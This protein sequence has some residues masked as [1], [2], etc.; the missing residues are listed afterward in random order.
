QVNALC[1]IMLGAA[2]LPLLIYGASLKW[3]Q[4]KKVQAGAVLLVAILGSGCGSKSFPSHELKSQFFSDVEELG[5]RGTGA[6]Q[7]NKPRSVIVDKEQNIFVMDITGRMQKFTKN[8]QYAMAWQMPETDIGKPKGMT[9]DEE[10]NVVLVEPHYSRVNHFTSNGQLLYQWGKAGRS[11][12]EFVFPRSIAITTN[13]DSYLSEY[14]LAE[15]IQRFS[16]HGEKFLASIGE[17]G[18]GPGQFNRV[19]GLGLDA[20]NRLYAADSCNHRIQVFSP[21]GKLLSIFGKAGS[22]LGEMSYPY[23][24]RIDKHGYKFVCEFGNSRIQVFGPANEPLEIIGNIGSEPGQFFN[25]WSIAL[26]DQGNLYVADS[27]NHRVQIF[28]RKQ[29]ETKPPSVPAT[30]R[31]QDNP[32]THQGTKPSRS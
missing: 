29:F 26:D 10:G 18:N 22:G 25:P 5:V 15:R 21:D 23:D 20:Q 6:G 11:P 32:A 9:I 14:G 19:E 16:K 17:P 1:V 30:A 13:G 4:W 2:L 8:R 3:F 28:K 27:G 31:N 7:F 24:I 12:G